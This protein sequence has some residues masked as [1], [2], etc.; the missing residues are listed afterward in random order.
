MDILS[1]TDDF[2]I[3]TIEKM[4]GDID[5]LTKEVYQEINAEFIRQINEKEI[6]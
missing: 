6:I 3:D 1:E 4:W 5:E 2:T